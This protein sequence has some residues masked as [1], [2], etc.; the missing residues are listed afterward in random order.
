[1][2]PVPLRLVEPEDQ[3]ATE[4]CGTAFAYGWPEHVPS[5]KCWCRPDVDVDADGQAYVTHRE[6]H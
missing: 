6:R 4:L 3:R 1:V 2:N 5:R